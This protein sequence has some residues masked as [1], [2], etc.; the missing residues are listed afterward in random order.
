MLNVISNYLGTG[1]LKT[2]DSEKIAVR[3]KDINKAFKLTNRVDYYDG[4]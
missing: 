2:P 4:E 1:L 3:G